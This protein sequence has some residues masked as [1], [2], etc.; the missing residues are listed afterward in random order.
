M[1]KDFSYLRGKVSQSLTILA[2]NAYRYITNL[3]FKSVHGIFFAGHILRWVL[4]RCYDPLAAKRVSE[5]WVEDWGVLALIF[6]V[7]LASLSPTHSAQKINKSGQPPELKKKVQIGLFP[8]L[9]WTQ[10]MLNFD[11]RPAF[12][13]LIWYEIL[14]G[15]FY[16]FVPYSALVLKQVHLHCLSCR[17]EQWQPFLKGSEWSK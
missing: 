11:P 2:L 1:S 10:F 14:S 16:G 4:L 15:I 13:I 17:N 7:M 12:P 6:A 3:S 9:F 5:A 8:P